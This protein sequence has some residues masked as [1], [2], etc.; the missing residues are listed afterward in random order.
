M[1][2]SVIKLAHLVCLP[3][4]LLINAMYV[5]ILVLNVQQIQDLIAL[6]ANYQDIMQKMP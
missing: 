5:M 2:F 3:I 1:T 4:L 6:N